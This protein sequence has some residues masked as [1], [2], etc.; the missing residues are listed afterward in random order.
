M[1]LL[2]TRTALTLSAAFLLAGCST[3]P[4]TQST[5]TTS[6]AVTTPTIANLQPFADT[7]G[8]IATYTTA[9]VID[10]STA[11]FQPLGTNARTCATCH[12]AAQGMSLTPTAALTLFTTTSGT[13]PLFTTIDGA[14]YPTAPTGDTAS[15][16]LILNSGLIRIPVELPANT[17]FTLTVLSDPYNCALTIDPTTGRQI[18]ST[19][20][21]PL[22][23]SSLAYLSNIMWDTRETISPLTTASTFDTNLTADLNQQL[24]DAV[25]IHE[26]GTTTPTAAQ[27]AAILALQQT[28]Y[29]AQSTDTLAGSLSTAGATG[30]PTNLAAVTF[31]PGINDA[32]GADP[33]GKPFNPAA[34]NLYTAWANSTNA[35]QASIAR[36]ENIFNTAPM[37]ITDVRGI[38]DNP[39][40][41]APANQRGS[42][43]F[44]HDTP[45][46]GNHSL[47]LPLD[48]GTSRLSA[49]ETDPQIIAGLAQLSA[50]TLPIYQITGCK[51]AANQPVTYITSDPG[52]GLFTGQCADINRVKLPILRGLAARAPYFH[53]GS[54]TNLTQLVNFYN[55]RF[56]MNLNQGQKTDL[57]NF[58]NAL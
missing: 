47:P 48:T 23:T 57:I 17:Q 28:L 29:T 14:N 45:N 12:Q 42:C 11:F 54:A 34:F 33:T 15:H 51:N 21:R 31:Y 26:Q 7:T 8:N 39:A 30:G 25:S 46:I 9:S 6:A 40:V 2:S 19:Y 58:L 22:P 5:T 52:K 50:P 37:Q 24:L 49:T 27:V 41:G 44:C 56:Q 35:Q 1:S 53:N 18:V 43:S 13:D 4:S 20:R 36:G 38:N 55:A 10:E 3:T 16:S 32:F